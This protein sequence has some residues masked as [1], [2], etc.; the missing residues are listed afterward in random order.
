MNHVKCFCLLAL[1]AVESF[2]GI[3]FGGWQ[4]VDGDERNHP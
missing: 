3:M 1:L 4:D 2:F